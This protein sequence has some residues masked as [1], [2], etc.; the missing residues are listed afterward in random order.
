MR[1]SIFR[2]YFY[3]TR[4][5]CIIF[6]EFYIRWI[7]RLRKAWPSRT[8]V[9]LIEGRKKWCPVDDIDIDTWF[10]IVPVLIFKG[11]FC[12]LFLGNFILK[13]RQSRLDIVF[14]E[15]FEFFPPGIFDIVFPSASFLIERVLK[16]RSFVIIL[17]IVFSREKCR[18][19]FDFHR[20]WFVEFF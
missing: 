7:D 16:R 19:V 12:S 20:N 9:I 13:W 10:F 15:F 11:R 14:R 18:K 17:M 8:R 3:A 6:F 4:K 2:S 5:E 1:I